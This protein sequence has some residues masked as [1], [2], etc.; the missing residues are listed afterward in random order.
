MERVLDRTIERSSTR[1]QFGEPIGSFQAVS[2]RIVDM[3][4]RHE[5]ARLMIY[6]AAAL[7]DRGES[8][9]IASALAK[10]EVSESAVQGALD[11]VRLHGA[12]GYTDALGIEA[13][14]R[15][16]VGGLAYSGTSEIQKNIIARYLGVG[17]P[18]RARKPSGNP[19]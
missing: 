16:A 10:L 18:V 5:A 7:H 15:D 8:I 12:E 1:T 13:E 14:L 4:R 11:A 9:A 19:S 17:R 2:H 3:K 6:K